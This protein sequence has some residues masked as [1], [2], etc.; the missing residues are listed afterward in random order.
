MAFG[1]QAII[2]EQAAELDSLRRANVHLQQ[3]VADARFVGRVAMRVEAELSSPDVER[4]VGEEAEAVACIA[5]FEQE[6][7]DMVQD[8]SARL[9]REKY[10]HYAAQF[11]STEGVNIKPEL[12]EL[13]KTDGTY[14][15]MR[16]KAEADVRTELQDEVLTEAKATCE[17]ELRTP[18]AIAEL[19]AALREELKDSSELRHHRSQT[20]DI[21]E[22]EWRAEA[23]EMARQAITDEE[24]AREEEFKEQYAEDYK[25]G[26]YGQNHRQTV[27]NELEEKWR[28]ST[29][30]EVA[31][32]IKDEELQALLGA[33]AEAEKAKL[34]K[35]SKHQEILQNFEAGG[36]DVS[37]LEEN[38]KVTIYLG[39]MNRVKQTEKFVNQRGYD[40]S[41]EVTV[42]VVDC[43][44]KLVLTAL[45]EGRFLVS[46]DSLLDASSP[47]AR[48][49]AIERGTVIVIGRKIKENKGETLDKIISADMPL[50]Y[51]DDTSTPEFESTL[52]PVANVKI[53]GVSARKFDEVRMI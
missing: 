38:S 42:P 41:R 35:E 52:L 6:R 16:K 13:F 34:A 51:D 20:R 4:A 8:L 26:R 14:E 27:R 28:Q 24:K 1:K 47:Y 11:R 19:K 37:D 49:H 45:A 15:A 12:D 7:A 18:E 25:D 31:A 23:L 17:T 30:E 33:R 32:A 9:Q 10:D 29:I 43:Q 39:E 21:L 44:R 48:Q 50:Y 53:D 5:V 46:S 36:I 3:Q 40:D 2:D 22:A